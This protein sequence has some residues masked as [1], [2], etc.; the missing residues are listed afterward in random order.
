MIYLID[1]DLSICRSFG[2][3]LR[4]AGYEY[5]TLVSAVEFLSSV[6]PANSDLI[7]LDLNLPGMSGCDLLKEFN[8]K[9]VHPSVIMVTAFNDPKAR[10]CCR[11]YGVIAYLRKPVDGEALID[12]INY[13][14]ENNESVILKNK[15]TG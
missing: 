7:V 15:S 3:I 11:E 13:N 6:K 5:R 14:L 10:E 12:L 1:D 9:G 4:S 8:K 2:L